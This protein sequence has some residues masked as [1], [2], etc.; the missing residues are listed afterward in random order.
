VAIETHDVALQTLDGLRLDGDLAVPS[1]PVIAGVVL[2]HP[3]P[4]FGGDRFSPVVDAL[5]HGLAD[6]GCLV[7]RF[8]FRG[9]NES[10]G[11]HGGGLDERIDAAAA[12][13]LLAAATDA[14]LWLGGYSFGAAVALDVAHPRIDGW[15]AVAPPLAAMPGSRV[16]ATD[17]R[18]KHLLLAGHDQYSPPDATADAI[19]SWR[20]VDTTVLASADHFLAG[21]LVQL[22]PW[23]L[24]SIAA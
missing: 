10:E 13:D 12:V 6:A 22:T 23:A 21:H 24:A 7:L 19:R 20:N 1:A 11:S 16:A 14:P 17:H 15:L 8:D 2:C 18:P 3:H 5:F 9:V 4:S